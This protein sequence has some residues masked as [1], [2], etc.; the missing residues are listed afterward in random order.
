MIPEMRLSL[1]GNAPETRRKRAGNQPE[2]SKICVLKFVVQMIVFPAIIQFPLADSRLICYHAVS[3]RHGF[4]A[5]A[6][7]E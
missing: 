7:M 2:I 4:T 3:V 6:S 5:N 1:A